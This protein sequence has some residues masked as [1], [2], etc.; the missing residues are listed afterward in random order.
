MIRRE[1]I[2]LLGGAAVAWPVAARAQQRASHVRRIAWLGIGRADEPSPYV[3]SLRAGLRELG[4]VEG[5]NLTIGLFWATGRENMEAAAREL[6]AS[7]PDV[8]VTQEFMVF[9][10]Q[11]LKTAKPVVFGFSGDPVEGKLVQSWPRPGGNF[12]GMSYLALELVG[13]RIELLK[14]WLPQTRRVAILARPQHPG[15][16][17]E[18]KASEAVV[19][20][21]GIELSY[22][23]YYSQPSVP[24]R[25][26]GEL[27]TA[28]RAIV[29]DGC[30]A[31]VIFPDSV[32]YEVSGRIAQFALDAKLPSVSGWSTFARKG[33]LMTYG[34][35]VRDL[36]RSLARYVDRILRGT[37]PSELPIEIPTK[38]YLAINI[39]T[40]KALGLTVPDKLLALAD[41]VIE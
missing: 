25:N 24:A 33:C 23:P 10:M 29:Q 41:E 7:D 2:T 37:A 13:K 11:S 1:F 21:L 27:E 39:N 8:I 17:L 9:A 18:R 19:G 15:E 6:L 38:F 4:W 34:P 14:E 32:M 36:Y 16:H 30:D 22:F 28:F 40:A 12:T 5:G 26:L 20:K 3:D 31:L 35:N